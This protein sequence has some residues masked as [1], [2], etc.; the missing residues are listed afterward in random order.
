LPVFE[1]AREARWFDCSILFDHFFGHRT[2]GVGNAPRGRR[3]VHAPEII[4]E[5]MILAPNR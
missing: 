5:R 1:S 3:C 4:E 2:S